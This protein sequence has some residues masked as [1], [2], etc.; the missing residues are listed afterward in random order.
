MRT[1]A[2]IAVLFRRPR[3]RVRERAEFGS[4]GRICAQRTCRDDTGGNDNAQGQTHQGCRRTGA[5]PRARGPAPIPAKAPASNGCGN[6]SAKA[7]A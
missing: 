1:M 4:G 6:S 5:P 3:D 7:S 2:G